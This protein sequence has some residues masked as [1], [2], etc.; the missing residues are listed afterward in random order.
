MPLTN[1]Q[2][3]AIMRAYDDKRQRAQMLL[4]G[5]REEIYARIPAVEALE[6]EIASAAI[7]AARERVLHGTSGTDALEEAIRRAANEKKRLL[8]ENGY[9]SDYL[10]EIYDCPFCHDTGFVGSRR[11][12]CFARMAREFTNS[13][14]FFVQPDDAP[15]LS[16]FRLDVYPDDAKDPAT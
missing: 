6:N 5:R 3:D 4:A 7:G 1:S 2:Y 8:T 16:A 13:R 10:E 12:S 9:P 11:C 15:D 14:F